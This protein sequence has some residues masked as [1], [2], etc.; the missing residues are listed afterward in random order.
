V[1]AA[2]EVLAVRDVPAGVQVASRVTVETD[3]SERPALVA[4]TITLLIP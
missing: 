1:R 2:V 3:G 4:E